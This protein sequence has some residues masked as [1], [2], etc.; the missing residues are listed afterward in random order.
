[1]P[2]NVSELAAYVE[3]LR[4]LGGGGGAPWVYDQYLDYREVRAGLLSLS[5][6]RG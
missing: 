4:D 2:Y 5:L 6:S 3:A 1:M